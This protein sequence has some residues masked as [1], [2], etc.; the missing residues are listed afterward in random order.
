VSTDDDKK[1]DFDSCNKTYHSWQMQRRKN[2]PKSER[3]VALIARLELAV[4]RSNNGIK[5][6]PA[7]VLIQCSY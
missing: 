2:S 7:Q 1:K 4:F 3:H 5:W 6:G